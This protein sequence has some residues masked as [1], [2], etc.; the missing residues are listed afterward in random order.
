MT[1]DDK[2]RISVAWIFFLF[3]IIKLVLAINIPRYG[4]SDVRRHARVLLLVA[5]SLSFAFTGS[6][7][8]AVSVELTRKEWT[9]PKYYTLATIVAMSVLFPLLLS[10]TV[11][12]AQDMCT[13]S[14]AYVTILL[15]VTL[16]IMAGIFSIVD[17]YS[18]NGNPGEDDEEL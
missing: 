18:G 6:V 11:L 7:A 5:V 15:S 3:A 4:L 1:P 9:S 14:T 12:Y 13:S 2:R 16:L 8:I 17:E 10:S